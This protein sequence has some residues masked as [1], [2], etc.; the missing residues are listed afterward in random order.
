MVRHAGGI[1]KTVALQNLVTQPLKSFKKLTGK[2]G[3]LTSH[4]QNLYHRQATEAAQDF[5][6][7]YENPGVDVSSKVNQQLA[8]EIRDNKNRL[9]PII[10]NIIFLGRHNIAFRGHR[11]DGPLFSRDLE[12][13]QKNSD[14]DSHV[15]NDGNFSSLLQFR[16]SSGDK[17]LANHLK[18]TSS[19][20]TYIS[21]ITQNEFISMCGAEI[22]EEI[23]RRVNEAGIYSIGFDETTDE[24]S[25]SQI[26]LFLR[27]V[28]RGN[29][30]EDFIGFIDAFEDL[31]NDKKEERIPYLSDEEEYEAVRREIASEKSYLSLTGKV[32]GKIVI[33]KMKRMNLQMMK[34][35]GIGTD[36]CAVMVSEVRG[37]VKEIQSEAPNALRTSC[38]NHKLNNSLSSN[39]VLQVKNTVGIMKSIVAFFSKYPKRC[40]VLLTK[41]TM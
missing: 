17:I 6:Y 22:R 8:E 10:E 2:D 38:F 4:D 23:L 37:A 11:D 1:H 30:R 41:L 36:E 25:K 28:Y 31:A 14:A 32:L 24:S 21:K 27:Y 20:A 19:R 35:V 15:S 3:I 34:C 26:S 29:L 16:V 39:K 40:V 33:R 13:R 7:N 12:P 9:K 18:N 5:L